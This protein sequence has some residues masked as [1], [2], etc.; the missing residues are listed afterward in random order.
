MAVGG[1]DELDI[2]PAAGGVGLSLLE[3]VGGREMLGLGL[4]ER[5][6][7]GLA[8]LI[9]PDTQGVVHAALG[10]APR[11]P[12]DDLDRPR[13]LLAPD[14]VLGPAA[15]MERRVDQLGPSVGFPEGHEAAGYCTV[16]ATMMGG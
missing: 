1:E 5:D 12:L 11:L 14:E 13:R 15:R 10:P 8:R 3:A 7:H 16:R 4:D 6:G 9:H 2:E